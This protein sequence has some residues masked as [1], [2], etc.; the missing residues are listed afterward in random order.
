MSDVTLS[1]LSVDYDGVTVVRELDLT[2]ASGEWL[3]LIGPN[4]AGKTTVLR[5][6][7]RLVPF[8][9][10]VRLGEDAVA[11]LG[12]REVARRV[13]MLLQEPQMPA[14]MT[15][16]QYVLLG[17]SPHLRYLG[18]ESARDR[19]IVADTLHRLSLDAM[20]SR[21]LDHLSGGER[22]RVAIARALTQQAPILL[23]D[24]PTTSLDVGRQQAVLE[25]IDRLRIEQ[26]LTVIAA[27]HELTLAGQYADRLALL[28][29]GRLVA[30]GPPAEILTEAVISEHYQAQVKVISLNGSGKAVVPVRG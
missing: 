29:G 1:G 27:M 17:R 21:P 2:V 3:A 30:I 26:E 19:R 23:I 4:G 20:A 22:Q 13:A 12:A 28:V 5:A 11:L 10:D 25:L 9:G 8:E 16:S 15:V 18:R 14:G 24:E 7:A 6:I